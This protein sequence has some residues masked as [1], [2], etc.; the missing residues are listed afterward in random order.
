MVATQRDSRRVLRR[1]IIATALTLIA[2][3]IGSSAYDAWRLHAQI[4]AATERELTNLARAL[5][6]EANR[7]LQAADLLLADTARWYDTTGRFLDRAAIEANLASRASTSPYVSVLGIVDAQGQQRYR[8]RQA[9]AGLSNVSDRPYFIAQRDGQADGMFINEPIVTRTDLRPAL[10]ISRRLEQ[11]GKFAGIVTG[12]MTLDDLRH[13]YDAIMLDEHSSLIF[14]FD[15]GLLV[16]RLPP[17]ARTHI[18]ARFPEISNLRFQQTGRLVSP[19]DGREKFLVAVPVA[20]RHLVLAVA[21]DAH[22]ALR[23]WREEMGSMVLRDLALAVV[24]LLTMGLLIRQLNREDAGEQALRQSEERYALAMDAANEGHAEWKIGGDGAIFASERWRSLHGLPAQAPIC[25]LDELLPLLTLDPQDYQAIRTALEDHLAGRTP[26]VEL[27]YRV[28]PGPGVDG[29]WR[30]IH[31]RGRCLRDEDGQPLRF[32]CAA[33]DVSARKQAEAERAQLEGQLR[34][35][36]HLEALGTLAGGIAHDFNNILGAILGHGE[37]AQR[38]AAE[39]SA[40]RRHLDRVM[41]G[42]ARARLLVRRILDFSRSSVRERVRVHLQSAVEEAL[43]LLSAAL[44]PAVRLVTELQGGRA[45]IQGD[46]TQIHQ[47]V[48]N[49]CTN[50]IGAMPDGG[51]LTVRLERLQLAQPQRL[52]HGTMQPGPALRLSVSD[53]GT[54]IAPEVYARMF[55]PFFS[56]KKVGEGTG[57]GLSVVHSIMADLG[58]TIDVKTA[59]GR[60]STFALW[61]PM[62]GEVESA[63]GEDTAALP[64]GRGQTVMIVDDET[65]LLESAEEMLAQLGYEPVGFPSSL[66]ALQAFSEDPQRFDAVLTDETMPELSGI[67]LTRKLL[68]LKPG[69]AVLVMSGYGGDKLEDKARAAGARMLLHKP[70]AMRDIAEGLARATLVTNA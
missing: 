33:S 55:D 28:K 22:D 43:V 5:S 6:E 59:A 65:A 37:M 10:V 62:A 69:L 35:A 27:E 19:V 46:P 40:L 42:G 68:E 2:A 56:T 57:L 1:W 66:G 12:I 30:W 50:A 39:G 45:A 9:V 36:Q 26:E 29:P 51:Q 58:G 47:L 3:F 21:R 52:S 8:S 16:I 60:G 44:P 23:P 31:L 63:T 25:K 13:V 54:G 14:T 41:Q 24:G 48:S 4:I 49:L 17:T 11:D 38:D 67:E 34:Q 32:F 7:S 15:D 18:G 53:T 70:L 20:N 64:M 61:L